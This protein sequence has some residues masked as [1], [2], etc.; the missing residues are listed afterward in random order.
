MSTRL[1][2]S[3]A[4]FGGSGATGQ[5]VISQALAQGLRV[6]T[7]VRPT[8]SIAVPS[9]AVEIRVGSLQSSGDV[10]DTLRGCEAVCCVFGPRPPFTDLFCAEATQVIVDAMHRCKVE[11]IVCQTGAMIGEYRQNRTRPFQLLVELFKRVSPAL[12]EDRAQQEQ[13]LRSS[14]LNWTLVKPPKLVN[15]PA[16][17]ALAIGTEVKVGLGSQL[18]RVDLAC[19]LVQEILVPQ[20]SEKAVFIHQKRTFLPGC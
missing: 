14:G 11:R 16:Q 8:A 2:H 1:I 20:Y 6:R 5:Q 15:T 17:G 13:I 12:A 10:E 9:D 19:F 18:S 4:L 3:L 7:L